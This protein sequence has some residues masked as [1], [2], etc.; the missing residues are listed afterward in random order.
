[1][2]RKQSRLKV[3]SLIILVFIILVIINRNTDYAPL[4][5]PEPNLNFG[6]AVFFLETS[7]AS[8]HG[9]FLLNNRQICAI[10]SAARMNLRLDVFVLFASRM[11]F[12]SGE[13]FGVSGIAN[14]YWMIHYC[15]QHFDISSGH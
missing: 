12:G 15:R 11:D 5:L 3:F 1:M 7:F 4:D 2:E 9:S 14:F 10:E 6:K 13:F 8:D